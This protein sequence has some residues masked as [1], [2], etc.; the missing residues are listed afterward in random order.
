[1]FLENSYVLIKRFR[2]LY[3]T[4]N[5]VI[6]QIFILRKFLYSVVSVVF[7]IIRNNCMK[8]ISNLE[9]NFKIL[10]KIYLS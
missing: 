7:K 10:D 9:L 2:N 1:M 4:R 3:I 6:L 5:I 8:M